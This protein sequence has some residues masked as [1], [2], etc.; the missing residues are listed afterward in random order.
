MH[1]EHEFWVPRFSLQEIPEFGDFFGPAPTN[2]CVF[3]L[4]VRPTEGKIV[5][6][7]VC[8]QCH[9]SAFYLGFPGIER[10]RL[11]SFRCQPQPLPL[12]RCVRVNTEQKGLAFLDGVSSDPLNPEQKVIRNKNPCETPRARQYEDTSSKMGASEKKSKFS[13]STN[14]PLEFLMPDRFI[15]QLLVRCDRC[16]ELVLRDTG[17]RGDGETMTATSLYD[18]GAAGRQFDFKI[19]PEASSMPTMPI[20][21]HEN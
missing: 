16:L 1:Q 2:M 3:G 18:P 8:E 19:N 7:S 17:R 14:T 12:I 11:V 5:D 21:S 15:F 10:L 9:F 6:S 20:L 13:T 4:S